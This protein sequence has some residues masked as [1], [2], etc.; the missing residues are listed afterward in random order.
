MHMDQ[1]FLFCSTKEIKGWTVS[2]H[3]RHGCAEHAKKHV[4]VTRRGLSGSYSWNVDGTRH[5]A[6]A[7]PATEQSINRAKELAADALKI[8]QSSLQFLVQVEGGSTVSIAG[9][10]DSYGPKIR[11]YVRKKDHLLLLGC[12]LGLVSVWLPICS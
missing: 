7:F 4:H 6:H 5:D 10:G 8:P 12:D 11:G 9:S 2:V 3:A 1:L